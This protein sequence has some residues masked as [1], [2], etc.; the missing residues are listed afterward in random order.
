MRVFARRL[1]GS[2]GECGLISRTEVLWLVVQ[3]CQRSVLVDTEIT[4]VSLFDVKCN[5]LFELPLA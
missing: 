5:L 2:V 3:D 4:W 1:L